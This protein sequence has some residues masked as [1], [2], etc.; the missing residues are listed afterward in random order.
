MKKL[1]DCIRKGVPEADAKKLVVST[2]LKKPDEK[3]AQANYE[4]VTACQKKLA[5]K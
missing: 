1:E 4:K 5:K 3:L 2:L